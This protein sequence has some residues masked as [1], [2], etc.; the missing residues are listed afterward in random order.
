MLLLAMMGVTSL[1]SVLLLNTGINPASTFE[2]LKW[3]LQAKN[4]R[5]SYQ[6]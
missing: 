3:E 2:G 4:K 6:G 1:A 5:I